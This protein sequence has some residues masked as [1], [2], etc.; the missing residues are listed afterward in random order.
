MVDAKL[1]EMMST[2]SLSDV[3]NLQDR[4]EEMVRPALLAGYFGKSFTRF[5]SGLQYH[6]GGAQDTAELASLARVSA[7]DHVLDVCCFIGGPALQLAELSSL[8][9]FRVAKASALPFEDGAYTV[10]WIQCSLDSDELWLKEFD[11]V[12]APGGRFAFTFQRRGNDDKR[13]TLAELT[14]LLRGLGYNINHADDITQRDIEIGWR[15]LD[16]RLSK[17]EDVFS[18]ALGPG[19]VRSARR[20]FRRELENMESTGTR[21]SLLRRSREVDDPAR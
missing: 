1:Q 9:D 11:H 2:W 4:L 5:V 13:W 18:A 17:R 7:N 19:W 12:L 15:A 10:V 6:L 3:G 16:G 14:A 21:E 8:V 20:E